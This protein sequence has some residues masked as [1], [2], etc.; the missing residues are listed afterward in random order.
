MKTKTITTHAAINYG[1]FFQAFALQQALNNMGIENEILNV[2]SMRQ[3]RDYA[4]FR[5]VNSVGALVRN[6]ITLFHYSGLKERKEKF[7]KARTKNMTLTNEYVSLADYFKENPFDGSVFIAGSDQIWNTQTSDYMTDYMLPGVPNKITYSV[8]GGT[9]IHLSDL[10]PF[11]EEIKGFKHISVRETDLKQILEDLGIKDVLVTLDPTLLISRDYYQNL[12][13]SVP[14]IQ[15][16]YIFL[17]SVKCDP[18]VLKAAKRISKRL[19]MPVYTLFNTYRSEK[20]RFYG[21]KTIYNAGPEDFLNIIQNAELVLSDSFHGNVFSVILEKKF[22]YISPVDEKGNMLRD[23]RIDDFLT[24]A[25]LIQRKVSVNED[26]RIE[27]QHEIN[28]QET[29]V[30]LERL[31]TSSLEYLKNAICE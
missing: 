16:K 18:D 20:N 9:K 12:I 26:L 3:K 29:K 28:F 21:L 23:D 25:C 19:H 31:Q 30:S 7:E 22:Y 24:K 17:Y 5:K 1:A 14:F 13:S 8:S 6:G 11:L 2:Q 27:L 15:G 4:L 10:Q